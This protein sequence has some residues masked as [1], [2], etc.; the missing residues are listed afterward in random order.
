MRFGWFGDDV[1]L[2]C[3]DAH[4]IRTME[5]TRR[6][7]LA[8]KDLATSLGFRPT[9]VLTTLLQAHRRS[10]LQELHRTAAAGLTRYLGSLPEASASAIAQPKTTRRWP[11][12]GFTAKERRDTLGDWTLGGDVVETTDRTRATPS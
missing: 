4:A 10:L 2:L 11:L 6:T 8:G 5:A 1:W 7:S 3:E 9:Y 12:W